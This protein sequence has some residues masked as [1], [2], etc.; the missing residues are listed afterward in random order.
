MSFVFPGD[1][2]PVIKANE[3]VP[4]LDKQWSAKKQAL[5]KKYDPLIGEGKPNPFE[6]ACKDYN[7]NSQQFLT[8]ANGPLKQAY[9]HYLEATKKKMNNLIYYYQYTTWPEQ[10]ELAKVRAKMTWLRMIKDQSPRFKSKGPWCDAKDQKQKNTELQK[11]DD[12]NCQYESTMNMGIFTITSRCSETT[13]HFDF[14]GVNID[15]NDN[16]ES[17]KMNGTVVVGAGKGFDGPAGV[18][19]EAGAAGVVEFDNTGITDVGGKAGVG[20]N[21]AG[22]NVA[23]VETTVTVNSGASMSG[24]GILGGR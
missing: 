23:G 8:A 3:A 9:D 14:G 11:F 16:V 21:V 24:K 7:D 2:D 19:V 4:P 12:I 17:G 20:V 13:G 1:I 15:I 6:Q 10:F 5:D 18:E 22:Q